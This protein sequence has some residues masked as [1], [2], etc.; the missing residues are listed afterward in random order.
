MNESLSGPPDEG[1]ATEACAGTRNSQRSNRTKRPRGKGIR[2]TVIGAATAQVFCIEDLSVQGMGRA[3]HRGFRRSVGDAGFGELRRQLGY[4]ADWHGRTVSV[5]DRW[6]PSSKTC[7]GCGTIKADLALW[8]RRWTCGTCGAE[9]DR[10][11][12]AATNIEREGLRLLA[13][14]PCP[15]GP[16][17]RRGGRQARGAGAC[18]VGRASSA[19]QLTAVKRELSYRGA[20]RRPSAKAQHDV[21]PKVEEG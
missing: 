19:G 7:S 18:A 15:E 20:K 3:L 6:Y 1:I 11:A 12:N 4:K 21:E 16:T 17:P 8:A 10:D 5:V 2:R 9:H 13:A 14:E